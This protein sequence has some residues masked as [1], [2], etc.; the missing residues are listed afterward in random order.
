MGYS[1]IQ[2]IVKIV[3]KKAQEGLETRVANEAKKF[4]I[5]N[6]KTRVYTIYKSKY[7]DNENRLS[8]EGNL[9]VDARQGFAS[10]YYKENLGYYDMGERYPNMEMSHY[11]P[12]STVLYRFAYGDVWGPGESYLP[13][14][15][16]IDKARVEVRANKAHVKAMKS[17]LSQFFNVK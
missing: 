7:H 2:E 11:V 8:D 1:S 17:Y 10:I 6:A 4:I 5:N 9:Q 16:F 13:A 3:E 15:P 12:T 14:S